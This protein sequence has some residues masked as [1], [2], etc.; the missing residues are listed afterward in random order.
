MLFDNVDIATLHLHY[1]NCY[2]LRVNDLSTLL[3]GYWLGLFISI[4]YWT[5]KQF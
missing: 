5:T 4:F 1:S 2:G 3:V